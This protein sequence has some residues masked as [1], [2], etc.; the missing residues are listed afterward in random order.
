MPSPNYNGL[1]IKLLKFM[2]NLMRSLKHNPKAP[3]PWHHD[4][5]RPD[6]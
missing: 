1:L 2:F 5:E 6:E 3:P 4:G